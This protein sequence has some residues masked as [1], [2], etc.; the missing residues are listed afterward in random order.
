MG[1]SVFCS[2][3]LKE[4]T[5]RRPSLRPDVAEE[6]EE[7]EEEEGEEKEEKKEEDS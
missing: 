7:E 3:F 2:E 4:T 1:V 6:E 5:F